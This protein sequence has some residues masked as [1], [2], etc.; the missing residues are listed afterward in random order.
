MLKNEQLLSLLP[1]ITVSDNRDA[2]DASQDTIESIRPHRVTVTLKNGAVY[3]ETVQYA[4]G[5]SRFNPFTLSERDAKFYQCFGSF[6][7]AKV[8]QVKS[9]CRSGWEQP[10]NNLAEY[11]TP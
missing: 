10:I 1:K 3:S 2:Q 4:K 5:D 9:I 7:T 8:E 11:L 6:S